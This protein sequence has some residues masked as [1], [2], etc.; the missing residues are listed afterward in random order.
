MNMTCVRKQPRLTH[1]FPV[2]RTHL[3]AALCSTLIIVPSF[4]GYAQE[5]QTAALSSG[6][7]TVVVTAE[8]RAENIRDIPS[9]ISAV[10]AE[11]LEATGPVNGTGDLLR[12]MPGV[13]FND[14]QSSNLGEVSIRGSGTERATGADS[15]VGLFVNGAYVG[16]S[17]LGGRNF[18]NVDF[19][20]LAR[21]EVLEGPQ[22]ALYG[23]NAEYGVVNVVLAKPE[24]N[25]S[26]KVEATYTGGLSQA[27][28]SAIVNH[29][30]NDEMAVR[31]GLQAI[32]QARGFYYDPNANRYYD[33]TN[34]WIARGQLRYNDGR[35]DVDFL[36][37]AQK[38][39]LPTF[40]NAY[41]L[42]PGVVAALP[43][44]FTHP[45]RFVIPHEGQ[46]DLHQDELRTMLLVNYDFVW[47]T[48]SSTSMLSDWTS[49]QHFAAAFD[50][51]IEAKLQAMGEAGLYPFS[52]TG[53]HVRDRTAYE[54]LHLTGTAFSDRLAWLLGGE[55]LWQKDFY[56]RQVATSPCVV[57][58]NRGICAGTP[59]N[60][61]CYLILPTS[62]PCPNPFPAPFGTDSV[63]PA[64]QY[65]SE[66]IY[67]SLSYKIGSGFMVSGGFR[68]SN[69]HKS[70]SQFVYN[71]YTTTLSD[72]PSSYTFNS[73][74]PNYT[75]TASYLIPGSWDDLLYVKTGTGYRAGG[76]N[77][78][79]SSP[80]APGVPF[81]PT[82]GNEDTTSY[83]IGLKGGLTSYAYFTLD[84]YYSRTGNAI[85]S[86]SD[87]C[88]VANVCA[89]VGTIFNINAGTVHAR[90]IEASLTT[91][92]NLW[93]GGLTFNINGANQSATYVEVPPG[94]AGLEIV[95]S[96]VAQIPHWTASSDLDYV[97]PV[98]D[99]IDAFFHLSY[100]GQWGGAQDTVT[101]AAP[102]VEMS[103]V[104]DFSLRT[105]V[106][107]KQ[108]QIAFFI[109]N[110]TDEKVALLKFTTNGF[111]L[112]NR[113]NE[114][115]RFGASLSYKW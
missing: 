104:N 73:Q 81:Q 10:T 56:E 115:R 103:S 35:L 16:S 49:V 66:A 48:L 33:S 8:K 57:A 34:G 64:Q 69:D 36:V 4:P 93:G 63:V 20:D 68:Y 18:R 28:L 101:V 82:Y 17:T 100:H 37:D 92:F 45:D 42:P 112:A 53:T 25:D 77:N 78:G 11:Q 27:R 102:F 79:T 38:L 85:A 32:G 12:S 110:L 7:E 76:I 26:G 52:Q 91:K 21:I 41:V 44:G 22:G 13:R 9:T 43:L 72:T 97:H 39:G 60:P 47:G 67:G 111:P 98:T 54:D 96:P 70:A 59:A 84:A 95:G 50:L 23:R 31:V 30:L 108:F 74:R 15:G 14:L 89:K 6:I 109:Q 99:D 1:A 71:L 61:I 106:D 88:T 24:F 86:V 62:L 87:G 114:P 2:S 51:A 46:D 80:L 19:F 3:L 90:G 75:L 83:E 5:N 113:Y 105:G 94:I 55:V 58:V 107:Y 65:L 29:Q 40:V